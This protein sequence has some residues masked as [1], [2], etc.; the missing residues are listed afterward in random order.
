MSLSVKETYAPTQNVLVYTG[1]LQGKVTKRNYVFLGKLADLPKLPGGKRYNIRVR[2]SDEHGNRYTPLMCKGR[3]DGKGTL[4]IEDK[5]APVFDEGRNQD[6]DNP[7]EPLPPTPT[8]LAL[9]IN[10]T[11]RGKT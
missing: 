9:V 5:Y 7:H 6:M 8:K 3:T 11:L 1:R 4:L 2:G 10:N